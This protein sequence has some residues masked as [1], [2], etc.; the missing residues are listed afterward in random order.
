MVWSG[1][2][3]V[4]PPLSGPIRGRRR[5]HRHHRM[6]L[7]AAMM[8]TNDAPVTWEKFNSIMSSCESVSICT[9]SASSTGVELDEPIVLQFLCDLLVKIRYECFQIFEKCDDILFPDQSGS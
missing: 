7:S 4:I 3:V 1:K 5:R 9:S 8:R 2:D 6:P